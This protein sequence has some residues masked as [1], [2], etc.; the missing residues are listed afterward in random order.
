[1]SFRFRHLVY[2]AVIKHHAPTLVNVRVECLHVSGMQQLASTLKEAGGLK[3][4][5]ALFLFVRRLFGCHPLVHPALPALNMRV[6]DVAVW[7][8]GLA[9]VC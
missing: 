6:V 9:A 3:L 1:M 2:V 8:R 7:L 4:L 5:S